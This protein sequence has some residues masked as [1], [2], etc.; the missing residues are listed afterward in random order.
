V[1]RSSFEGR[2]VALFLPS[3]AAGGVGRVFVDLA[4]GFAARGCRVEMLLCRA[5]GPHLERVTPSV[6][7]VEL[8][9]E[10][11]LAARRR[12]AAAHPGPTRELLLPILLPG[13]AS[14][15]LRAVGALA[16]HLERARPDA[17]LAGKTHA[18]LAA[19]WAGRQAGGRTRIVV[20][21]RTNLSQQIARKREWRWR[22]IAPVVARVYPH[23]H[24][25]TTVSDGVS[26]DLARTTGIARARIET[27]HNPFDL[28]R[29][30]KLAAEPAPHPWLAPGAGGVVLAAGRLSPQKDFATLLDAFARVCSRRRDEPLR[31]VIL[32]EGDLRARLAAQAARLGIGD[33]V[34]LPGYATNPY[35]FM[36]RAR[37]FVLSSTWEGLP[38]TLVEALACGCPVVSTDCPSG[39]REILRGGAFGALVPPGD[40]TALADAIDRVL[41]HPPEAALLRA[42][43]A[44]FAA[45]AAIDRYLRALLAPE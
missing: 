18:N 16:R 4:N 21:E 20:S 7:V 39:P 1:D 5:A 24:P 15:P 43:S 27:I 13:S 38:G 31:L 32:G 45:D 33:R 11:T 9:R 37:V 35:A 23:A 3:L 36:A 40:A 30:A 17:L 6:K 41:A 26:D 34:A 28:A 12:I 19:V 42:R 10:S 25:I 2:H 44:D 8:E 14:M 22:H 29:I